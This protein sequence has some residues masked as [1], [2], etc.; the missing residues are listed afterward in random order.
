MNTMPTD[1]SR[2]AVIERIEGLL[3]DLSPGELVAVLVA[4]AKAA[5]KAAVVG[6]DEPDPDG[7]CTL[8]VIGLREANVADTA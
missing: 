2:E 1:P 6:G 8:A 3:Q 7:G 4:L 5:G